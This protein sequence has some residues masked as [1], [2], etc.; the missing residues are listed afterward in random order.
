MKPSASSYGEFY[1]DY[2]DLVPRDDMLEAL[3]ESERISA[4]FWNSI[5]I[6]KGNYRYAEGKWS[7]K[8]LLQHI[9]DTERIFSYRALAFA[10]GEQIPLSG[11]DKNTYA[12]N[13]LADSRLL[14]EMI[15]ELML[16]LK[17]TIA[18][19][20]SFDESVLD[21]LG[22]ASGSN[23]S[24]R[25]VGFIIVGHEIHHMNVVSEHYVNQDN[26]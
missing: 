16:V 18:L 15:D 14:Q 7:M 12:D 1:R 6:E 21:N 8:E 2:V 10:R 5:P 22:K 11:Y 23:L 26:W 20:K 3:C 19:F 13:C 25:A 17:S 9:I 24:V 4:A